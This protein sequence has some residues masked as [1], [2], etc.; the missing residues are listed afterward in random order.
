MAR[1]QHDPSQ[2]RPHGPEDV[3]VDGAHGRFWGAN[4]AAGLLIADDGRVL[5]QL[6]A[7]WSHLGGTWGI[8]GGARKGDETAEEAAI[9]E[10]DEEAGVPPALVEVIGSSV[11]DLGYWSYTTV[12]A[13]ARRPFEPFLGD[14]ESLELRWTS[15]A[16]VAG[17]PLHPG[18]AASWPELRGRLEESD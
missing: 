5:L 3:W 2:R 7:V 18:F 4:G 8:P 15:F 10:A 14:A 17:L 11:F 9:R 6:R 16:E 12:L 13:R 1:A